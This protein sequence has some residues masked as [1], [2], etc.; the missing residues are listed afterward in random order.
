MAAKDCQKTTIK[1]NSD[2]KLTFDPPTHLPQPP[3]DPKFNQVVP[4]SLHTFPENC[5][6]R[7]SLLRAPQQPGNTSSMRALLPPILPS[8]SQWNRWSPWAHEAREFLNDL[9]R[10]LSL[11][12]A[13]ARETFHLFNAF[14][15]SPS[16]I[17]QWHFGAHSSRKTMMMLAANSRRCF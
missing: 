4:W 14:Q 10:R 8:Q 3:T 13:D 9:G 2:N 11:I 7:A 12:T 1:P 6:L 15:F 17:M 16:A 5:L